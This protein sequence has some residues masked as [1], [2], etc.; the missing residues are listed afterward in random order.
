MNCHK[1]KGRHVVKPNKI[2]P[3]IPDIIIPTALIRSLSNRLL[4]I[5][6]Q[7]LNKIFNRETKE[8]RV[9]Q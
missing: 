3:I 8:P 5:K 1:K 4:F 2:P 7:K 9:K 6:H